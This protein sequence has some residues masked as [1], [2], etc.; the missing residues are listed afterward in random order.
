MTT[1]ISELTLRSRAAMLPAVFLGLGACSGSGEGFSFATKGISA[2]PAPVQVAPS[3]PKSR[4]VTLARGDITVHAPKGFCIDTGSV[5]QG[6][7]ESSVLL[8]RCSALDG[9]GAD[10]PAAV[11]SLRVS[12]RRSAQQSQVTLADLASA[13]D[14]ADVLTQQQKGSLAIVQ[15]RQTPNVPFKGTDATRWHAATGLDDRL[16]LMSLYA[17]KGGSMAKSA[18]SATLI[19]LARGLSAKRGNILE[20]LQRQN[21]DEARAAPASSNKKQQ[22]NPAPT[23]S[24]PVPDVVTVDPDAKKPRRGLI[25]RLFNLS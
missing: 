5:K 20:R 15:V 10:G 7:S 4:K 9:K 11:M 23:A 17:P 18:G 2:P 21:P 19:A 6:L 16:V 22:I 13:F 8:A 1:G 24:A 3:R 12:A 14:A 25:G